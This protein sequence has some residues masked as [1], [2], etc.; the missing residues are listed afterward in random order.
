MRKFFTYLTFAIVVGLV[1]LY[2][3]LAVTQ[4]IRIDSSRVDS[5]RAIVKAGGTTFDSAR[6]VWSYNGASGSRLVRANQT[7]TLRWVRATSP[8]VQRDAL[9]LDYYTYP[10]VKSSAYSVAAKVVVPPVV[11]PPVTQPTSGGYAIPAPPLTFTPVDPVVNKSVA[12][13]HGGDLQAALNAAT[14]GTEV[15]MA[16]GSAFV[17]NYVYSGR[18]AIVLRCDTVPTGKVGPNNLPT[19]RIESPNSEA[20]LRTGSGASQLR[21]TG[22]EFA[23]NVSE[24]YGIV[25]LGRGDE[26]TLAAMPSDIALDRVWIHSSA[27]GQTR[28]C[29]AFNGIRLAITDSWLSDCHTKGFDAQGVGGWNGPGPF[30]IAGNRIE[31]SGQGVMFGGADPRIRDVLPSDITITGNYIVKPLTWGNGKWTVKAAFELKN[32]KRVRFEG[33]VIEN[34]WADAQNGAAILLQTLADNNTSWEWTTVQ[35]VLIRNNVIRNTTSGLNM[36]ARVAY[37]GGPMP[38]NPTSRVAVLNNLWENV[39]KDPFR[40]EASYAVQLLNDLVDVTFANNTFTCACAMQKVMSIEGK[41]QIRTRIA[42]NV[43]G[44]SSYGIATGGIPFTTLGITLTRNVI[45]GVSAALFP[46]GSFGAATGVDMA[47]L[48]KAIAGV[49]R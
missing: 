30:L 49:V 18:G 20:A 45:P 35:D 29:V 2:P 11:T 41:P 22:V 28:R 46:A 9:K 5:L 48:N 1:L 31:A 7:D 13:A 21:V 6:F 37:N 4:T 38:T 25:V 27:T 16:N 15:V 33:N 19:C 47:T 23:S 34:H 39:G 40:N 10:K 24:N 14:A 43:F 32:G 42:D 8:V 36:A 17:G 12:V 44:T 3:D 26:T